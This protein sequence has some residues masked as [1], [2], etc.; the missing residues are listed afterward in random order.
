MRERSFE[1]IDEIARQDDRIVFVGSDLGR[2]TL[3]KFRTD[4]PKRYF[5]E[6][7]SEQHIVSMAAG[8]ALEGFVPFVCSLSSFITRRSYEQILIDVCL[9]NLPVRFVCFGGGSV[10]ST[11]GP[12]HMVNEDLALFRLMPNMTVVAACDALE[13]ESLIKDS[14]SHPGPIY[15]RLARGEDKK[16]SNSQ[17]KLGEAVRYFHA[18]SINI[19]TTGVMLQRALAAREKLLAEGIKCGILHLPTVSPL[20]EKSIKEYASVSSYIVTIEEHFYKGGLGSSL[21]EYFSIHS[22]GSEKIKIMAL[23]HQFFSL[24][25]VQEDILD[26][27]DLS[28][29]AIMAK[30]KTLFK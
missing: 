10:Y 22:L 6:G 9:H 2:H 30:I 17:V 20:D 27:F 11:L 26:K 4:F 7:I 1:V 28:V 18:E 16:V 25:G 5:M 8:L 15:Y 3:H 21:L 12:T 24:Y 13:I 14:L 19:F 29:E 23:P